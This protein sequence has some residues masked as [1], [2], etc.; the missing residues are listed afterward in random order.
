[1]AMIQAK[2]E[3]DWEVTMAKFFSGLN[4]NVANAIEL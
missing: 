4:R 3:E 1:M 2:I